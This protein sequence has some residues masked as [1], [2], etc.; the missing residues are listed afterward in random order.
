M[1]IGPHQLG[2]FGFVSFR[3]DPSRDREPHVCEPP[4][5]L[6]QESVRTELAG[7]KERRDAALVGM[8]GVDSLLWSSFVVV[9]L[10]SYKGAHTKAGW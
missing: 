5:E 4:Q 1:S 7:C 8:L 2:A 9:Y 3:R 6:P 10:S